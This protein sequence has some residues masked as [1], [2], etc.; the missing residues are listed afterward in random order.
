[1]SG[2]YGI[3]VRTIWGKLTVSV[4]A[5]DI[6]DARNKFIKMWECY[7]ITTLDRIPDGQFKFW[8]ALLGS[9][10]M[11]VVADIFNES[12]CQF[13]TKEVFIDKANHKD[14]VYVALQNGKIYALD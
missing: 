12:I 1:M 8:V 2:R 4:K 13:E 5:N 6:V 14:A 7:K 9:V 10:D 3:N 11:V